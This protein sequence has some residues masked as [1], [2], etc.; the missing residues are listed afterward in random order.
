MPAI[1]EKDV[2]HR[3]VHQGTR[4]RDANVVLPP[5]ALRLALAR[6]AEDLWGLAVTSQG[7]SQEMLDQEGAVSRLGVDDLIL[8]LTAPDGS[9]AIAAVDRAVLAA[10]IEVQTLGCVSDQAFDDRPYTTTDA[11]MVWLYLDRVIAGF[12]ATLQAHPMA[13]LAA[14]LRFEERA[15][16][17]R[18]A[19]L[20]MDAAQYHAM[21]AAVEIDGGRRRGDVRL[22]L[23]LRHV[24]AP[25]SAAEARGSH[26]ATM[27]MLP[28]P[29]QAVLG[30][31]TVPLS[32][33]CALRPG[34][35]LSLP[36]GI[37]DMAE[38]VAV[39]GH[40]VA[41]GRLGQLNGF[42][43]IRLSF[44]SGNP[45]RAEDAPAPEADAPAPDPAA[46]PLPEDGYA[47]N[48]PATDLPLTTTP[49]LAPL[50]AAEQEDDDF[51]GF[52]AM[53]GVDALDDMPDW[54]EED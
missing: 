16:D 47:D 39:G 50:P 51:A 6:V 8:V 43:A 31:V 14:G 46:T 28:A 11:A 30:R 37:L 5:R 44:P 21:T 33:A 10:L 17:P 25:A 12:A 49:A 45:A 26:A 38:L 41:K 4:R 15:V 42:R 9:H 2:L 54:E 52:P 23:P 35:L 1:S 40:V 29:V 32:R 27:R 13:P 22:L 53:T 19:A 18:T 24:K 7:I 36:D 34:D 48:V 20:F 3:K